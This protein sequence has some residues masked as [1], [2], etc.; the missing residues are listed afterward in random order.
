MHA[1][2]WQHGVMTDLGE[3][4][5]PFISYALAINPGGQIVGQAGGHA[6]LW[7]K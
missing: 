1:F 5:G 4:A 3:V 7:T 6:V 2:V